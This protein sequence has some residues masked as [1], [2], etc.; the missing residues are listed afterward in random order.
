MPNQRSSRQLR[1]FRKLIRGIGAIGGRKQRMYNPRKR[2]NMK[3][4]IFVFLILVVVLQAAGMLGQ[5]SWTAA[6]DHQN[7]MTQLGIKQ[8]RPGPSGTESAPNHANYD[9]ATANPFPKLPEVLTL[10][11]GKKV[12]T[13]DMWWKQRRPEI[14]EDFDRE[15]F[16]RVPKNVP[17]V[18]WT[19]TNTVNATVA[20][21]PVIGKQL[22]GHDDN[23]AFPAIAVD[24]QMTLVVPA[25]AKGPVPV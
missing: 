25:D 18:T 21:R 23:S 20:S 4:S 7:M 2:G 5:Q 13:P 19:V 15:V 14:V 24:I 22:V 6:E 10:R 16:G 3:K 1:Q 11:N 17:N 8:L 12:T 9:E